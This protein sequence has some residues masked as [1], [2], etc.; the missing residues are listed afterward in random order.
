MYVPKCAK[1]Q[2]ISQ[3]F[4][5]WPKAESF[6]SFFNTLNVE[7]EP[8]NAKQRREGPNKSECGKVIKISS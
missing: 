7:T 3:F 6:K 1:S 2:K 5:E 4:H 8:L